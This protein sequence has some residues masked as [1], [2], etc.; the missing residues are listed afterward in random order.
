MKRRLGL[1]RR[2]R[3]NQMSM[4]RSHKKGTKTRKSESQPS[5]HTSQPVE[6]DLINQRDLLSST[7]LINSPADINRETSALRIAQMIIR[8]FQVSLYVGLGL[9]VVLI[10]AFTVNPELVSALLPSLGSVLE[11]ITTIGAIFSPL[12]AF[13]LGYY[14]NRSHGD[15]G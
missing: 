7:L 8:T 1:Q 15:N 6:I 14:Y 2:P 12:L 13:I 4:D 10:I 11:V 3:I 5:N 9:I